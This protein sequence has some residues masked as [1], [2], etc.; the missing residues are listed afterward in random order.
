MNAIK[1]VILSFA[2]LS[3]SNSSLAQN[4]TPK[5]KQIV[6]QIT[7]HKYSYSDGAQTDYSRIF[8][9]KVTDV[10]SKNGVLTVSGIRNEQFEVAWIDADHTMAVLRG[11][12][13]ANYVLDFTNPGKISAINKKVGK[14]FY[15][16]Y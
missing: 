12:D 5:G 10:G 14:L 9:F 16:V 3:F 6:Q 4:A 13:G 2:L 7:T 8:Q 11:F 1:L 15:L